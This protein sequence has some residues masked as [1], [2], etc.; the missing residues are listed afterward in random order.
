MKRWFDRDIVFEGEII[1]DAWLLKA[2]APNNERADILVIRCSAS[3]RILVI[4]R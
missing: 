1:Q 3:L 2:E 4:N